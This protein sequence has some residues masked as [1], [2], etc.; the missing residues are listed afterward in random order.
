VEKKDLTVIIPVYNE[1]ESLPIFLENIS[2][3]KEE[4]NILFVDDASK[5][6]SKHM[7]EEAGFNVLSHPYNKGY[8]AALKTGIRNSETEFIIIMDSDMQHDPDYIIEFINNY[9]WYDIVIG[10]RTKSSY[11]PFFRRPGK[12][13]LNVLAGYSAGFKIKDINSGFRMFKKEDTLRYLE[14]LPNGFSFTTTQTL[15]YIKGGYSLKYIPLKAFKRKGSSTVKVR[16]GI[17]TTFLILKTLVLYSPMKFFL[18][19]SIFLFL[20]GSGELVWEYNLFNKF[21]FSTSALL[22]YLSSLLVFMSGMISEQ[23]SQLKRIGNN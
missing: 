9:K 7:I 22:L 14:I 5:D 18:P 12:F 15:L 13:F 3:F 20:I 2:K 11:F 16:D 4:Y 17:N 19:V 10:E 6:K 1:E 23:I 8:G 21:Q